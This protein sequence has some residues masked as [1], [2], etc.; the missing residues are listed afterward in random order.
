MIRHFSNHRIA[1][2]FRIGESP[3]II[4]EYPVKLFQEGRKLHIG[5]G[6]FLPL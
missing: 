5:L 4:G 6:I 3:G 1:R 2:S